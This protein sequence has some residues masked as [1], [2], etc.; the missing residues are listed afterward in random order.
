MPTSPSLLGKKIRL[1]TVTHLVNHVPFNPLWAIFGFVDPDDTPCTP[2]SRKLLYMISAAGMKTILQTRNH[3]SRPPFKL[4]QEKLLFLMK[5]PYKRK[6]VYKSFLR[7]GRASLLFY[8]SMCNI[9][10]RRISHSVVGIKKGFWLVTHQLT[11]H[12]G[13][14]NMEAM[15]ILHVTGSS[16]Y[17]IITLFSING[18][19]P[20]FRSR[21]TK[22]GKIIRKSFCIGLHL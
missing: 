1:F 4:F 22:R 5:L 6:H 17:R 14:R 20:T 21:K 9:L 2:G 7:T 18:V 12:S 8:Q 11:L 3:K 15:R 13:K 19:L 16:Y 10:S